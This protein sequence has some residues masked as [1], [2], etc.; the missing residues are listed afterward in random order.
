[1]GYSKLH[2]NNNIQHQPFQFGKVFFKEKKNLDYFLHIYSISGVLYY[3][4]SSF[5]NIFYFIIYFFVFILF[6]HSLKHFS[7]IF[8]WILNALFL[9]TDD[10]T[11]CCCVL[12]K[13][14]FY[15]FSV[16]LL[17]F[18]YIRKTTDYESSCIHEMIIWI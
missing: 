9:Y 14:L 11:E 5:Y 7:S 17:C 8:S 10:W 18:C 2:L 1:M 6:F 16:L 4:F 15:F 3:F 13:I 12:Y